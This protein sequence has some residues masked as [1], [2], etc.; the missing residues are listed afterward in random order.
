M[1]SLREAKRRSNPVEQ[2]GMK[3]RFGL[4]GCGA[5]GAVIARHLIA[6]WKGKARWTGFHDAS[7]EAARNLSAALGRRIPLRGLHELISGSDWVVEAA[8]P[9]AVP[10]LLKLCLE[11]KKNLLAMSSGGLLKCSS[12]MK[13]AR[14]RGIRIV[15]PSGAIA[16]LDT[17]Q[18]ARLGTID[19]AMITT[20]KPPH[21]F[22]GA[23]HLLKMGMDPSAL[24]KE[25]VLFEGNAAQAMEGFPA[26]INVAATLSLAT[27]LAARKIRVKIV[28]DPAATRNTHHVIVRGSSGDISTTVDN[29]PS[30]T[31]PKTSA[32][33]VLAACVAIDGIFSSVRIGT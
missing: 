4:V 1:E 15:V 27:G 16:G 7:E 12:L 17:I 11:K 19:E 31:N 10:V 14:S 33:A 13:D 28:A 2:P 32:L 25:T 21:A 22:R 24:Q 9:S 29:V 20:R 3:L 30:K 8:S 6:R 18:A 26:N 23:P 5:M